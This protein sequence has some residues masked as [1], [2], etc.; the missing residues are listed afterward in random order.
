[1]ERWN[2]LFLK[3]KT[4]QWESEREDTQQ[5]VVAVVWYCLVKHNYRRRNIEIEC[6]KSFTLFACQYVHIHSALPIYK[7]CVCFLGV[8]VRL[9][10]REIFPHSPP[11]NF[12]MVGENIA[13]DGMCAVTVF[14]K[15]KYE[16]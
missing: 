4:E 16:T 6:G 15:R 1:M 3:S 2:S 10:Q 9:Q 5:Y 8:Y 11:V 14:P 12:D 13:C 7:S